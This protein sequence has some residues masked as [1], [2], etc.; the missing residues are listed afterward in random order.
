MKNKIKFLLF[1]IVFCATLGFSGV[2]FGISKVLAVDCD[3]LEGEAKVECEEKKDDEGDLLKD[4]KK[5]EAEKA[6]VEQN[7]GKVK[8]AVYSTEKAIDT[9]QNEI[10]KTEKTVQQKEKYLE[11]LE[12]S[13]D[14]KKEAL[15]KMIQESYYNS[16]QPF[17]FI[18]FSKDSFFENVRNVD[19]FFRFKEEVLVLMDEI[20][21]DKK[22]VEG[23][24]VLLEEK[25]KEKE[26]LLEIKESQKQ[27]LEREASGL[28]KVVAQKEAT[29][30]EIQSELNELRSDLNKL[31]GKSYDTDDVKDAIKFASGQTGV[32]K[33]FIFGMLSVESALGAHVGSCNYKQSRMSGTRAEIFKDICKE[34]DY[35]YKKQKVSCPPASY[36]G[37]GGAMGAAQFMSDTW[38]GYENKIANATG[39]NPPDPW[40]LVDGVM[41]MA[42]KLEND[43]ATKSG[44]TTIT[45]PC[46]GKKTSIS[47]EDYAAMKYLGWSC[48]ALTNYAPR[49]QSLSGGYK[50]L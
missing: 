22:S 11:D 43:G 17:I 47:W 9:T 42:L 26:E 7:L 31:L 13:M 39:H 2:D 34:L 8:G 48:Y 45:S 24:T 25:K 10:E 38:R 6:K 35:D 40:N 46:N 15:R 30:S 19:D 41:A 50:K 36:K 20:E 14:K 49:I 37:T 23:E 16:D 29:I 28:A 32:S 18:F 4:M 44:K 21:K 33:G 27:A 3:D 5:A 1:L 12:K